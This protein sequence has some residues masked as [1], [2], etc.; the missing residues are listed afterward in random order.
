VKIGLVARAED[1]GLG[2]QSWEFARAM[3]PERVLLVDM[4]ELARGFPSHHDR[5]PGSTVVHYHAGQLPE[6]QVR[7]WLE[8][9][10]V[11]FSAETFYDW[12]LCRWADEAGVA[13]VC[14]LNPE[15]L[16]P[17][18]ELPSRPTRWWAP[19]S[20]R[21]DALPGGTEVIP[22]PVADDRFSFRVP[23]RAGN[24]RVIHVVGHR[25]A[26]DRNGTAIV[27]QAVNRV[28]G[29]LELVLSTQ[30]ARIPQG[31][32][33]R[34]VT[35]TSRVGGLRDYWRL[36]EGF[37]VLVLPRRYGGLCLPVQEAMASG[38]AVVMSDTEPQRST[39][40]ARTVRTHLTSAIQTPAGR[41]PLA[42]VDPRSLARDL[43]HL[44]NNPADLL[45]A[46]QRSVEW[47]HRHRWSVLRP[48][49]ER[50]LADACAG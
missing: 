30:D 26:A 47:A 34:G 25:A 6:G 49:Y 39:W 35:I 7:E 23:E 48:L 44:A 2:I 21:L 8:G 9:L 32:N 31:R 40:P 1:R 20:W 46:Q 10:D 27:L 36:Y 41:L 4:G 3:Q 5:Y 17:V 45:E 33:H 11:V 42:N 13:T 12:R 22:V 37:D 24:L 19:T 50:R 28:R 29:P 15:F 18:A 14:Q 43:D 16:R 38:L